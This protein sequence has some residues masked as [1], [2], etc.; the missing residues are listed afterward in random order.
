QA[1]RADRTGRNSRHRLDS[2]FRGAGFSQTRRRSP[3]S[4]LRLRGRTLGVKQKAAR[5]D[6]EEEADTERTVRAVKPTA[7]KRPAWLCSSHLESLRLESRRPTFRGFTW[8]LN[9]NTTR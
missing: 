3:G 4:Q 6:A 1:I 8:K 2:V 5:M 7:I 9:S